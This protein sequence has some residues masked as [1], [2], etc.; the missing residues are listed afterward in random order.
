MPPAGPKDGATAA[1]ARRPR[2]QQSSVPA[3]G[4]PAELETAA[5]A[6]E[7]DVAA[8]VQSHATA[9]GEDG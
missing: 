1:I 4:L 5:A 7:Q 8:V 9:G 2:Q 6:G 3:T